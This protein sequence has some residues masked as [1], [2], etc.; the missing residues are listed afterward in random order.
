VVVRGDAVVVV[1]ARGRLVVAGTGPGAPVTAAAGNTVVDGIN[2]SSSE[3]PSAAALSSGESTMTNSPAT[4]TMMSSARGT[5]PGVN[6]GETICL[7]ADWAPS[8]RARTRSAPSSRTRSAAVSTE[9]AEERV[10]TTINAPAKSTENPM[11][12]NVGR[13]SKGRRASPIRT[14]LS[15]AHASSIHATLRTRNPRD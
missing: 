11:M 2:A 13:L 10:F 5:D 14:L 4:S 15:V 6:T 7:L 9:S 3:P 12:K 8:W 1:T